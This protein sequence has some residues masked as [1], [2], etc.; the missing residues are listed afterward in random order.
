MRIL[1][2]SILYR[3]ATLVGADT[4][5]RANPKDFADIAA[6]N[7]YALDPLLWA[8]ARQYILPSSDGRL[9]PRGSI[10]RAELARLVVQA[11]DMRAA[12]L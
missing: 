11:L 5:A 1:T 6:V 8:T 4:S 3:Y 9:N 10:S 2:P 12:T 7:A